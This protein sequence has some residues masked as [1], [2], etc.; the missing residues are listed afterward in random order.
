MGIEAIAIGAFLAVALIVAGLRALATLDKA[1]AGK[2]EIIS[3]AYSGPIYS[4]W[5]NEVR[6]DD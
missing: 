5:G 4:R 3:T 6:G 1:A 2:R